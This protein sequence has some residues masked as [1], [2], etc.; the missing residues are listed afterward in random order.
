MEVI[1]SLSGIYVLISTGHDVISIFTKLINTVQI[2]CCYSVFYTQGYS[3]VL[4]NS[5]VPKP[6]YA[7]ETVLKLSDLVF[8][9][10]V[11]RLCLQHNEYGV[12]RIWLLLVCFS[13]HYWHSILW[14]ALW[15][16]ADLWLCGLIGPAQSAV[17][18][19]RVMQISART[20]THSSCP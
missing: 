5:G 13:I 9:G 3:V 12:V 8:M 4:S 7:G 16:A 14:S 19:T 15:I 20:V 1:I 6:F 17:S 18:F 2:D 10:F 11:V